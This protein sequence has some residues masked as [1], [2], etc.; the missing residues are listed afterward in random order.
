[1]SH[2]PEAGTFHKAEAWACQAPSVPT[3]PDTARSVSTLSSHHWG[4]PT[5]PAHS[6]ADMPRHASVRDSAPASGSTTVASSVRSVLSALSGVPV[7]GPTDER[8]RASSSSFVV[9]VR[10]WGS[11]PPTA[12][13]DFSS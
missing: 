6:T 11:V 7:N 9:V 2:S 12:T 8:M 10:P 3:G 5:S 1:M 4:V 13:P